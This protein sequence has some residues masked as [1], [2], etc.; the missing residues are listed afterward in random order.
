MRALRVL[1]VSDHRGRADALGP[2]LAHHGFTVVGHEA[3]VVGASEAARREH[4][5][6]VLVDGA[7]RAGWHRIVDAIDA[8]PHSRIAVLAA[9]WSATSSAEATEAGVGAT[10]LKEVEGRELVARLRA[11][12]ACDGAGVPSDGSSP[13]RTG[14]RRPHA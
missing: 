8:I 14:A 13:G 6:V 1:I 4:P 9:Y 10:L 2:H 12:A 11:L 5:D 3:A 7:V